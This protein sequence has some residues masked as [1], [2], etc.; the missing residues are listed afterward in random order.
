MYSAFFQ[1]AGVVVF[2]FSSNIYTQ[3]LLIH[4]EL[5]YWKYSVRVAGHFGYAPII[6][7]KTLN[8]KMYFLAPSCIALWLN[9]PDNSQLRES[10]NLSYQWVV[11]S[12]YRFIFL[13]I[14]NYLCFRYSG[15]LKGIK[16]NGK[17]NINSLMTPYGVIK[18]QVA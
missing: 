18:W 13:S 2:D 14:F 3:S 9:F 16:L 15:S 7:E 1:M 17:C 10:S 5:W 4:F 11:I 6:R 12:L 8:T